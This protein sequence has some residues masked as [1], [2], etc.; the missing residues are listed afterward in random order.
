MTPQMKVSVTANIVIPSWGGRVNEIE[1][2][3]GDNSFLT[4][5]EAISNQLSLPLINPK[6]KN[7]TQWIELSINGRN[8]RF[9]P[10]YLQKKVNSNDKIRIDFLMMGGG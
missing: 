1:L 3:N 8:C 9:I 6:T 5:I 2:H 10:N 4:L 7:I